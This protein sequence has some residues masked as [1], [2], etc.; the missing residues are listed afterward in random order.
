MTFSTSAASPYPA[1]LSV[2]RSRT[3]QPPAE[4][5]M[6]T[7]GGWFHVED[8]PETTTNGNC[9]PLAAWIVVMRM[10]SASVSGRTT[11]LTRAVSSAWRSAQVRYSRSEPCSASDHARAWSRTNRNRRQVSR[12]RGESTAASRT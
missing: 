4:G 5:Q 6:T 3:S 11:S 1:V 2:L 7:G 12:Y 9:R 10:A 8:S